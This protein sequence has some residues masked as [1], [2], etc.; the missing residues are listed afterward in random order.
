M[1]RRDVLKASLYVPP[2]I[3]SFH[4]AP[5]F[6]RPGSVLP[7]KMP[8][9]IVTMK[10]VILPMDSNRNGVYSVGAPSNNYSSISFDQTKYKRPNLE[11]DRSSLEMVLKNIYEELRLFFFR[12][13]G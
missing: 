4:A 9:D 12:N 10:P 3:M 8:D 1:K 2:A 5:S 7:P 13:N 6:A 11:N